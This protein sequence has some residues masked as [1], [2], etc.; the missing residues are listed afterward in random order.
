MK[1][2]I[3]LLIAASWVVA[4]GVSAEM[5]TF[6]IDPVHSTL[7]FSIRHLYTPFTGRFNTFSGT[8]TADP[9]DL[10]SM[11]MVAEVDVLSID[12]ANADRD[13]HLRA[14]DFFD[15]AR[16]ATARF[17]STRTVKGVNN[18][19]QVSGNMTLRDRTQEV[20]FIVK[21]LGYGPD[22]LKGHRAGFH[23][24]TEINRF[25]FGVSYS[26]KLPGGLEVLGSNVEVIANIEAVEIEGQAPATNAAP[27][28]AEQITQLKSR[29]SVVLP[30][31]TQE[32]LEKARKVIEALGGIE[33][34]KVGDKAPEFALPS[35]GGGKVALSSALEK[36]PVVL[37]FYR[38]EWCPYCNLQLQALE[39][40]YPEIVKLGASLLAVSPQ[41]VEKSEIQATKSHLSF[42][43]LTDRS[44]LT[45]RAYR[46]LY[47]FPA[48]MRE[49][50]LKRF[51]I[52]L[53][54]YN[55][56]GRWELPVTATY[57][58]GKDGVVK[59]GMVDVDYTKRMEPKDILAALKALKN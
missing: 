20:T 2:K 44:G 38:G 58:I 6:R 50:Y 4:C 48:E 26:G 8:I 18:T 59:A 42:P 31:E 57:V 35:V 39:Q 21:G 45:M 25:D 23:M 33:G 11:K 1:M 13:K 43:L 22:F 41:K 7:H 19:V 36:G 15:T 54:E 32:A 34:L 29:P 40:A 5:K 3:V 47:Q 56:E 53:A 46:L 28:L 30:K 16:F 14:P 12:T 10:T 52:D 51:N 9:E 49:V 17:Q 55:G 24:T 27:S 37:V